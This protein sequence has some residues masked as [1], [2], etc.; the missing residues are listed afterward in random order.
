MSQFQI[1]EHPKPLQA[2]W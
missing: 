2:Y 1:P